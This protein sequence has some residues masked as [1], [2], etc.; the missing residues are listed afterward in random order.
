MYKI[1]QIEIK[2]LTIFCHEL[3]EE[4]RRGLESSSGRC[5]TQHR[6]ECIKNSLI[7][8]RHLLHKLQR[9]YELSLEDSEEKRNKK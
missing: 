7:L 6:D 3:S 4:I 1:E 5:G 9:L 2:T 8:S